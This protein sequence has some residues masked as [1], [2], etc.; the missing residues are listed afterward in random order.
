MLAFGTYLDINQI[1]TIAVFPMLIMVTLAEKFVSSM[2]G[3]G[4]YGAILLMFET[5]IVALICYWVVEWQY[6]QNIILAY[7]EI[8]LLIILV[9]LLLGRWTGLGVGLVGALIGGVIFN[10]LGIL[11]GLEA[12]AIS[13]RDIVAAVVGSFIFLLILWIVRK[14]SAGSS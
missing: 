3:R 14:G 13:L 8:I 4:Y 1:A 11:P 12:I 7:P 10:L 6:L 9:N 5:T 2:S